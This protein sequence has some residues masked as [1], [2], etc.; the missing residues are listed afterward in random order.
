MVI[1]DYHSYFSEVR[2][3]SDILEKLGERGSRVEMYEGRII[4]TVVFGEG[5]KGEI[6]TRQGSPSITTEVKIKRF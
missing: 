5:R 1:R 4:K 2:Q 3:Y 6:E